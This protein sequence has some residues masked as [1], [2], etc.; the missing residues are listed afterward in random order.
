MFQPGYGTEVFRTELWK[1]APDRWCFQGHRCLP[2]GGQGPYSASDH[3]S[4][5]ELNI[6]GV[7]AHYYSVPGPDPRIENRFHNLT[8]DLWSSGWADGTARVF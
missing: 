4:V 6:E 5:M 2:G 3:F 8:W 1:H 7:F